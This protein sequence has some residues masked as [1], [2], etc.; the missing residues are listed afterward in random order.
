MAEDSSPSTTTP[1]GKITMVDLSGKIT[2][3]TNP[4]A[5][6][7]LPIGGMFYVDFTLRSASSVA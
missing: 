7:K 2:M 4:D 1:S 5:V 3:A 6:V